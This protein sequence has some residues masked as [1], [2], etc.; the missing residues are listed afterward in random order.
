MKE[1]EKVNYAIV[2]STLSFSCSVLMCSVESA[3]LFFLT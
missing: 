1:N 2:P 3:N